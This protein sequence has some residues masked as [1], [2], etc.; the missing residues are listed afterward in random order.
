MEHT[1]RHLSVA[2]P[3][4][5][6]SGQVAALIAALRQ[7]T[8]QSFTLYCCINNPEGWADSPLASQRE[9]YEDNQ[10]SLALLRDADL[11]DVVVL[12]RSSRG[13]G[14]QG[15]QQ[16]VGWA[17]KA[18]FDAIA[19]NG[20][21]DELI[22]SLDADTLFDATYLEQL[23]HAMNRNRDCMAISVPYRHPLSGD[24]KLDR[25]MLRYELYMR[26]YMLSLDAIGSPYAFT[27]LGS[28]IAFPLWAYRRVGGI[29]PLQGGEDFYLL[30]KFVKSGSLLRWCE[31]EVRPAGRCSSRVPFGTGPAIAKGLGH[32]DETYPF[33]PEAAFAAV[34]ETYGLFPHLYDAEVET[35]MSPFLR[36][37]LRTEALWQPL[38][39]NFKSREH[40]VHACHERVDGL[41]ILQ[42][43]R[44]YCEQQAA[45]GK[46][47]DGEAEFRSF[48][49][50]NGI[51]L[52]DG[53]SFRHSDVSVIEA[54]R[55]EVYNLE[56]RRRIARPVIGC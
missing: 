7:Q 51:M 44:H 45:T 20:D 12:D 36:R 13:Q 17:R 19:A 48:C 18:L 5:A 30:Q 35:P 38:R 1:Y 37:Q 23:L 16:G 21:D 2:V 42:F 28:A 40:F 14:W 52:P 24:D 29:T 3:M 33:Y 39:T 10:A 55:N 50:R 6:E 8:V 26:H 43:L 25:A 46:P 11:A 27:A 22:V 56:R 34:A 4:L 41:R 9:Q 54:V 49:R 31:G 15:R 53:F 32:M 47:H